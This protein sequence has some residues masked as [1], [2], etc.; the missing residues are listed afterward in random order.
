MSD[1]RRRKRDVILLAEDNENDAFL[2]ERAF[3]RVGWLNTVHVVRNGDDAIAYL[4]GDGKFRDRKKH[5]LPGLLLLDLRMPIR[6]G[7]DVLEWI[8][9]QGNPSSMGIVVLT[10]SKRRA[11]LE[12]VRK[13]GADSF[14]T[15]PVDFTA[16][17]ELVREVAYLVTARPRFSDETL[18]R[19]DSSL[20]PVVN[21]KRLDRISPHP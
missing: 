13:L 14:L 16:F 8:Q 21:E 2:L 12:R 10:D 20:V 6:D 3:R 19:R 15:K 18:V 5:P 9:R 11:D 17:A 7:F 4:S 1:K